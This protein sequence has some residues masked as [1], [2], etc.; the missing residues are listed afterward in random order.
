[1]AERL[2]LVVTVYNGRDFVPRCLESAKRL[3]QSE[4][5]VD[6]LVLDDCSP[7]LEF[8]A[9]VE[10]LCR[11]LSIEYYRSPRNLG[12]PRNVNLGLLTAIAR[13]Y[14][15]VV[16]SNSDV[17]YAESAMAQ[18]VRVSRTDPVIGT[19]T[20]WSNNVSAYSLP[21]IDADKYIGEQDVVNWLGASLSG[22]YGATAIDIPAGISFSMLVPTRVLKVVGLMDPVYGRG[23]CEE[24]DFCLRNRS[25]GFRNVL[26]PGS[27][28]YHQGGGSN[29]EAGLLAPGLTTVPANERIIDFRFPNFRTQVEE[30]FGSGLLSTMRKNAHERIIQDA[31]RQ[32]GYQIRASWLPGRILPDEFLTV[33]LKPTSS[34]AE[35]VARFRGFEHEI[36]LSDSNFLASIVGAMGGV[37][38]TGR[39]ILDSSKVGGSTSSERE[40]DMSLMYPGRI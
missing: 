15:Y 25:F 32:F 14:D 37:Q 23:Y 21:N 28:V 4:S 26:A 12:I 7:D 34:G 2:L 22:F 31:A 35:A 11:K 8:S 17:V 19:V 29:R 30:Y 36:P 16:V 1:M 39:A 33:D 10:S 13:D 27:F 18:L 24:L 9:A 6:V 5:N 20:S 3:S 38:P 40:G